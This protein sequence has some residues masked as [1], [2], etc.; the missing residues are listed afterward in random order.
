[1]TDPVNPLQKLDQ[2]RSSLA[3][4][5]IT[6]IACDRTSGLQ[7]GLRKITRFAIVRS[8]RKVSM[9]SNPDIN[10]QPFRGDLEVEE[11]DTTVWLLKGFELLIAIG[12]NHTESDMASVIARSMTR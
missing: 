8:L 6:L 10:V 5:P 11:E 12:R 2:S 3:T 4:I 7:T 9:R 1:M